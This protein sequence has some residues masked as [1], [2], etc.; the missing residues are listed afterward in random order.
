MFKIKGK[1]IMFKILLMILT[2][3]ILE[4]FL[5]IIMSG[6]LSGHILEKI[7]TENSMKNAELY[8]DFIG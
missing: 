6:M 7:I 1:S 8:S 2:I 4:S 3:C 5:L